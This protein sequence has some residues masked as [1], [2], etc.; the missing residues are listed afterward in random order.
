MYFQRCVDQFFV[1]SALFA[2]NSSFRKDGVINIHNQHQWGEE[3]PHGAFH[4]RHQQKFSINVWG[5]MVGDCL[6]GPHD[7]PH[8]LTEKRYRDFLLHDLPKQLAVRA[9]IWNMHD[10]APA[11]FSHAVRDV[12][13]DT[14]HD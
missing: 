1:S 9:R 14:Y 5:G 10:G 6:V 11:H 4:S 3:N 12:L 2:Y 7:L 8:R 13:S